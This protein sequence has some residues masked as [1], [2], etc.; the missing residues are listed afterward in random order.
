LLTEV[1]RLWI[2]RNVLMVVLNIEFLA[3]EITLIE[4]AEVQYHTTVSYICVVTT[5]LIKQ[6]SPQNTL[7][8]LKVRAVCLF[9]A[10]NNRKVCVCV[11][12]CVFWRNY[13][14]EFYMT[15]NLCSN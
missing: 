4:A 1:K 10:F 14:S 15:I 3:V 9:I 6:Q 13:R 2:I 8:Q 12:V 11:C 7:Q 5:Q